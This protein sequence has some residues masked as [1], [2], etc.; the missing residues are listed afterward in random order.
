MFI[1]MVLF[2]YLL[3]F[4]P[5]LFILIYLLAAPILIIHFVIVR[6]A[7]AVRRMPSNR[8]LNISLAGFVIIYIFAVRGAFCG[9]T[10]AMLAG[11]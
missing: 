6:P 1:S 8:Y 4:F 11:F 2:L 10:P 7:G 9:G 3:L 5:V